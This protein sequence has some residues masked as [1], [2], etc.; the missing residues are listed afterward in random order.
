MAEANP[1]K[2]YNIFTDLISKR[3][4][5]RQLL[6]KMKQAVTWYRNAGRD[7]PKVNRKQLI[8]TEPVKK[9]TPNKGL[10]VGSMY[11]YNY[12]PKWKDILEVYDTHPVVI[13]IKILKDRF[14]GI[15]FHYL[16]FKERAELMDL[17]YNITNN[18]RFDETTKLKITYQILQ[19][20]A[21]KKLYEPTIHMYLKRKVKS[22]MLYVLPTEWELA[23]FLPIAKFHG[24]KAGQY[25]GH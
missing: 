22:R 25:K 24:P 19:K 14:L 5:Q 3:V 7:V 23:L 12:D 9:V 20:I 18:K 4:G 15:N 11:I 8:R 1:F 2:K 10:E 13:P 17:L 16:P 6:G 21:Q